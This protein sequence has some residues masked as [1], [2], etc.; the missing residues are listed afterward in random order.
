MAYEVKGDAW[1]RVA[2]RILLQALVD[3]DELP[4]F[5]VRRIEALNWLRSPDGIELAIDLGY[6]QRVEKLLLER[7]LLLPL[8]MVVDDTGKEIPLFL[9]PAGTNDQP[10]LQ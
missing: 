7:R 4:V 6:D 3:L 9:Q 5:P 8:I 10:I 1:L 2:E